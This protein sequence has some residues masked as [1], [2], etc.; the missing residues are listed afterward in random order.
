MLSATQRPHRSAGVRTGASHSRSSSSSSLSSV[1][2]HPAMSRLVMYGPTSDRAT[3]TPRLLQDLRDLVVHQV[4]LEQRRGAH[5][6]DEGEH[7]V[8]ALEVEVGEDRLDQQLGDLG[9]RAPA[10]PGGAPARRGS[11]CRSPS[12]RRAGRTW[13]SG[14]GHRAGGERHAH[15]AA[16]A[17]HALRDLGHVGQVAAL[18]GRRA[19]DLLHQH[20]DAHAAAARGVEAVLHGDVV[21]GDDGDRPRR[22]CR[23]RPAR[24]PSRSSSRRRC[25]SSRCAARPRRRRRC[26]WPPASGRAPAR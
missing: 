4:Q 3:V 19:R 17:V 12:R 20:G 5:A 10:A 15:A 26:G 13:A 7:A 21:V 2:E 11:R 8:A 25:S 6:V 22:P 9:A 24:P 14:G 16:V 18:L 23:R 1:T